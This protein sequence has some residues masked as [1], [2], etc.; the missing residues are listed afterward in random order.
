METIE[1]LPMDQVPVHLDPELPLDIQPL[2]VE[3]ET[4]KTKYNF[5]NSMKYRWKGKVVSEKF[6]NRKLKQAA[7]KIVRR[8]QTTN[9]TVQRPQDISVSA[10]KIEEESTVKDS[11]GGSNH[12]NEQNESDNVQEVEFP[13]KGERT[14]DLGFIAKMMKCTKC[15]GDLLLRNIRRE[16]R[17]RYRSILHVECQACKIINKVPT[18]G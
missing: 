2:E 7:G 3:V 12:S 13:V 8:S 14:V 4:E 1:P 15:Q 10:I 18:K 9:S 16:I 5:S 11:E 6:Y 17:R